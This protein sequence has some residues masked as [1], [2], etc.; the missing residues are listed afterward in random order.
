[1]LLTPVV[2]GFFGFMR[3]RRREPSTPSKIAW[4]IVVAGLSSLVM[5]V[6]C[7]T[8]DVYHDKAASLWIFTSYGVFT[9]SELFLSPIGLSLVSKV[10]PK[11]LTALMMGGWFLTT[12]I[13]GKVSGILAGFWDQ[14]ESK[15][16]FFGISAVAAIAAGLALMPLARRLSAVVEEATLSA[17]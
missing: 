5:V 10:A 7:A 8:T 13:G 11:R 14:F 6:A 3:A 2:V 15:G 4:G 16:L 17:D 9:I 1:V 12:S